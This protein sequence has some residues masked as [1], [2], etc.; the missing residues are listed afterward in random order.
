MRWAQRKGWMAS[1]HTSKRPPCLLW[2]CFRQ[3]DLVPAA[4]AARRGGPPRQQ[5]I[6]KSPKHPCCVAA[7]LKRTPTCVRSAAAPAS[8]NDRTAAASSRTASRRL[9]RC[10]L[11]ALA[12]ASWRHASASSDRQSISALSQ[13]LDPAARRCRS[14][15]SSARCQ[16][17]GAGEDCVL[18]GAVG[19]MQQPG[20]PPHPAAMR[21]VRRRGGGQRCATP[22][23]PNTQR[24]S[25]AGHSTLAQNR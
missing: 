25:G 9:C 1:S 22:G 23:A 14:R 4:Q 5:A 20:S 7:L 12:A 17:A 21:C 13:P 16:A 2:P 18:Q 3:A 15:K 24:R 6:P 11:R 19:T 10:R 8:S